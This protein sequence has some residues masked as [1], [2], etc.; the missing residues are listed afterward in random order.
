MSQSDTTP[1]CPT[2]RTRG[3]P[4]W[5]FLLGVSTECHDRVSME[6]HDGVSM[7]YLGWG[8]HGVPKMG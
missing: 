3:S 7:E 6:S 4:V 1:A 2:K 5:M 8:K